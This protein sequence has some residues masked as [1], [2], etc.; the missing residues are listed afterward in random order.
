MLVINHVWFSFK[1]RFG[2]LPPPPSHFA[3]MQDGG[4]I[5]IIIII[6]LF[7]LRTRVGVREEAPE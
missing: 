5:A 2:A 4:N 3:N 7:F 1:K 6:L